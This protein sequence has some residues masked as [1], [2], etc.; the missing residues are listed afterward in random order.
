[1][2]KIL[3]V[4]FIIFSLGANAQSKSDF[5]KILKDNNLQ[6]KAPAGYK[7]TPVIE[8]PDLAYNYAISVPKDS[9]EIRYTIFPLSDLIS[10]Y[11][12]SIS[13]SDI[14]VVD[15]NK[16]H[17]SMYMANILNISQ[18]GAGQMPDYKSLHAEM[19]DVVFGAD[20]AATSLFQCKS[21]FAEGYKH[22]FFILIHKQNIADVY[23][24]FL[25]NDEQ[26]IEDEILKVFS[27]I[28][29]KNK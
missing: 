15:P 21:A 24:S 29:F 6:F 14:T 1:M 13:D 10:D 16:Y 22:C 28:T 11:E 3:L 23:V 2:N 18:L 9:F 26:K 12:D 4:L 25:C 17:E 7:E 8:N 5:D 20:Y 19:T 27:S